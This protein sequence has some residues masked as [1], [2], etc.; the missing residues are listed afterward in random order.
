[1][2]VLS[3]HGIL[4][5]KTSTTSAMLTKHYVQR[6]ATNDNDQQARHHH[7]SAKPDDWVRS[8]PGRLSMHDN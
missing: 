3:N 8:S 7:F 2:E 4:D 1:M 6:H 5:L